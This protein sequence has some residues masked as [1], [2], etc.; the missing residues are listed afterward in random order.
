MRNML[1]EE[2]SLYFVYFVKTK[3]KN[4]NT[5][6]LYYYVNIINSPAGCR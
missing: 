3:L 5:I 4:I 6:K 2:K 1:L